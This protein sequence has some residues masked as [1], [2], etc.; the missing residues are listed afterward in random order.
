MFLVAGCGSSDKAADKGAQTSIKV[1]T[2]AGPHADFCHS[3]DLADD[4]IAVR[5]LDNDG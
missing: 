1:G 2:T 4:L 5:W 3:A